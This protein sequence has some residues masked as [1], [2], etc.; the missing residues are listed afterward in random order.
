MVKGNSMVPLLF[1]VGMVPL[2]S[3]SL[4]QLANYEHKL[5]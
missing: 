1:F 3:K 5:V 2:G 4:E